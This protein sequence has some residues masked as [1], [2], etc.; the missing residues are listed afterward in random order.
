MKRWLILAA[1]LCMTACTS[2]E[3]HLIYL[4]E[5]TPTPE[6]HVTPTPS[7]EPEPILFAPILSLIH[8]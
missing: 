2:Q 1:A 6:V 5:Q 4:P 8:I 3:A 7:P